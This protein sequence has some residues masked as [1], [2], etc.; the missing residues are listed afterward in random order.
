MSIARAQYK[1]PNNSRNIHAIGDFYYFGP[2]LAGLDMKPISFDR[3]VPAAVLASMTPNVPFNLHG[4]GV[5][6]A[7]SGTPYDYSINGS[8][9]LYQAGTFDTVFSSTSGAT[10]GRNFTVTHGGSFSEIKANGELEQRAALASVLEGNVSANIEF[11]T[12]IDENIDFFFVVGYSRFTATN[13]AVGTRI[14]IIKVAKLDFSVTLMTSNSSSYNSATPGTS[15]FNKALRYL[16]RMADGKH[17]FVVYNTRYHP[18]Y[19]INHMWYMVLD[20]NI[21]AGSVTYSAAVNTDN[22]NAHYAC[23]VPSPLL[24]SEGEELGWWYRA[25]V[26]GNDDTQ[27]IRRAVPEV[28]AGA[29]PAIPS[30]ASADYT[31]CSIVGMPEGVIL[32]TPGLD[33]ASNTNTGQSSMWLVNDAGKDFLI[34]YIHNGG[35]SAYENNAQTPISR[36]TLFVFEISAEDSSV[37]T[38]VSHINDAF[39][40]SQQLTG[41]CLNSDAKTLI[42]CNTNGFGILSWSTDAK[43]YSVSPWRSVV[44]VNR[45]T[46]D[47]SSQIWV[48]NTFGEVFIFNPDLSSSV[49]VEFEDNMTSVLY[50]GTTI[51]VNSIINVYNFVGVRMARNVRLN[52][53]GCTFAD[54]TTSK[55]I[56]TLATGDT[57]ERIFITGQGNVT[58]DAFLL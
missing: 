36:H 19:N 57:I 58:V 32:P 50:S 46:F 53:K 6:V 33:V 27:I 34:Y 38:Y 22:G 56:T 45:V 35:T 7:L 2:Y 18:S 47:N 15:N 14:F 44:G 9:S 31:A 37:L 26:A 4:T 30:N 25:R 39:G 12:I 20:T 54:G 48:E 17:L 21:T 51:G 49:T 43:T 42:V 16:G 3:T 8:H 40:Y 52:A 10:I 13:A 11:A 24:A 28:M 55:D 23:S 41:F 29:I 5:Q 1:L